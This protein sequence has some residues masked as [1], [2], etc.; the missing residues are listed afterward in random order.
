MLE[1]EHWDKENPLFYTQGQVQQ[2]CY[3]CCSWEDRGTVPSG[4]NVQSSQLDEIL[5]R[6]PSH[7]TPISKVTISWMDFRR[8]W[9]VSKWKWKLKPSRYG[10]TRIEVQNILLYDFELNRMNTLKKATREE[11]KK[12]YAELQSSEWK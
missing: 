7:L 5:V 3:H 6:V 8:A 1:T 9:H 10:D 4:S 2:G 11:L 12:L